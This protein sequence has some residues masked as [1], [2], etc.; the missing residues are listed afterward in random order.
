VQNKVNTLTGAYRINAQA[1]VTSKNEKLASNIAGSEI[2]GIEKFDLQGISDSDTSKSELKAAD[3]MIGKYISQIENPTSKTAQKDHHQKQDTKPSF[4][5]T[6]L[7]SDITDSSMENNHKSGEIVKEPIKYSANLK[8]PASKIN[9]SDNSISIEKTGVMKFNAAE[10]TGSNLEKATLSKSQIDLIVSKMIQQIKIAPCSLEV[11]LKPE[12]LGKVNILL[13]SKDGLISV[14]FIAQNGEAM[15][16]LNSNLKGIKD[17]LDQQGIKLQQM[18]VSLAN[19]EKQ[20][21]QAGSRYRDGT[22]QR[23]SLV[24]IPQKHGYIESSEQISLLPYKLNLLA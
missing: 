5:K 6:S 23:Q 21:N 1:S 17:N 16:L 10:T 3:F 9:L 7:T 8:T 4:I 13:Q 12:Y 2:S 22:R 15:D 11:S 18:D 20:D 14:N 19:Q 24:E